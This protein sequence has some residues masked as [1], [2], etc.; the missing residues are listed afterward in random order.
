MKVKITRIDK[1]IPLPIYKTKGSVGFDLITRRDTLIKGGELGFIPSNVIVEVPKGYAL[2]I[3][4]RSST[5]KKKGLLMPHGIGIL[6]QDYCGPE[7]ELLAHFYNFSKK[8][9]L[10]KKGERMAQGIFVKVAIGK[11][12]ETSKIKKQSRGGFGSTGK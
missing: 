12:Q 10:I 9:V 8:D 2:L 7:D 1:S 5:P 11:W 3:A 6:D 4:S